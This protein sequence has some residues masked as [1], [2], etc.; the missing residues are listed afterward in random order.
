ML[1]EFAITPEVFLSA[2]YESDGLYQIVLSQI[3]AE[4]ESLGVVRDLQHGEWKRFLAKQFSPRDVAG[5]KVLEAIVKRRR[6]VPSSLKRVE[7]ARDEGLIWDRIALAEHGAKA[8]R[9]VILTELQKRRHLESEIAESVCKLHERP[10]W[11]DRQLSLQVR[12]SAKEFIAELHPLFTHSTR[13]D[14]VDPHLDLDKPRYGDFL[15]VL[16]SIRRECEV[17]LHIV[18]ERS[19]SQVNWEPF[20]RLASSMRRSV[21]VVA[22]GKGAFVDEMVPAHDRYLLSDLACLSSTNG[23]DFDR[24]SMTLALLPPSQKHRVTR[25]FDK[26]YGVEVCARLIESR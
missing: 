22:R 17:I 9:G 18:A 11:Q 1:R 25:F 5:R 4:L 14:F 23:F 21:R 7:Q 15:S 24:K 20:E 26:H 10:W 12:R 8:V 19:F 6:C 13:I 16:R 2:S 3:S